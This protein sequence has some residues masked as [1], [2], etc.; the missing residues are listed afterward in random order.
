M[1][2]HQYREVTS[3][4]GVKYLRVAPIDRSKAWTEEQRET[5]ARKL[6]TRN[7][8]RVMLEDDEMVARIRNSIRGGLGRTPKVK[9]DA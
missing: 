6:C 8:L 4:N 2:K 5:Y 9:R 1:T 7:R 3:R